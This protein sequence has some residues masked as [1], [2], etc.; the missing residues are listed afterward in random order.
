MCFQIISFGTLQCRF[1]HRYISHASEF[2]QLFILCSFA[3]CFNASIRIDKF[4]SFASNV[5]NRRGI[6]GRRTSIVTFFEYGKNG[7]PWI[8]TVSKRHVLSGQKILLSAF[9]QNVWNNKESYRRRMHDVGI[10]YD[11]I[12]CNGIWQILVFTNLVE[13]VVWNG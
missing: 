1:G 5:V 9:L 4:L 12:C 7:R 10:K 13:M 11:W 2:Y 6:S 3:F 8:W